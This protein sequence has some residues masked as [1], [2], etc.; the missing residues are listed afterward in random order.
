MQRRKGG[1]GESMNI[2]GMTVARC[3]T[4]ELLSRLTAFPDRQVVEQVKRNETFRKLV[5]YEAML[6]YKFNPETVRFDL[7][8][9][10]FDT[11]NEGYVSL[12]ELSAEGNLVRL[13]EGEVSGSGSRTRTMKELSRIYEFFG[14]VYECGGDGEALDHLP[15][16]LSFMHYLAFKEVEYADVQGDQSS[17]ILG[18]K[19][20]LDKHLSG[21]V[22]ILCKGM[23]ELVRTPGG[24]NMEV[25]NYYKY[26]FELVS[27][28]VSKDLNYL[29]K[30]VSTWEKR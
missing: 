17:F 23:H 12:F 14:L 19:D 7:G 3:K 11:L 18:Q 1:L 4:Y 29:E 16:E 24:R 2:S 25:I 5:E 6:P 21:W 10:D 13:F 8:K 9:M 20:F 30:R 26:V 22:P 28:F 15:V 27:E